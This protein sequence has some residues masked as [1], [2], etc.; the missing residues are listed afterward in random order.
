MLECSALAG[1]K[2]EAY[3]QIVHLIRAWAVTL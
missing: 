2:I 3:F 1:S